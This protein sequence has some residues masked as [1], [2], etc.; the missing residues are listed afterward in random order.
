MLFKIGMR[1]PSFE[2]AVGNHN[3]LELGHRYNNSISETRL[4]G[5]LKIAFYFLGVTLHHLIS[6]NAGSRRA[7]EENMGDKVQL[8]LYSVFICKN[9]EHFGF[10]HSHL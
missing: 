2:I 1:C 4:K 7:L 5:P 10:S 8:L 9:G 6:Q 3:V